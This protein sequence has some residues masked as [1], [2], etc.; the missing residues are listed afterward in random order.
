MKQSINIVTLPN[1]YSLQIDNE[2]Y[3]YYSPE[4]L[5]EGFA[6]RVGLERLEVMNRDEISTLMASAKDGSIAKKLQAEV[7]E[8]KAIIR[9]QKKEIRAQKRVIKTLKSE[10]KIEY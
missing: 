10:L 1:G 4:S 5:V 8:L 3:M 6:I 2:S 7:T 9:D